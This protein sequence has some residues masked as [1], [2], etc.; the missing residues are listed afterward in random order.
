MFVDSDFP[1]YL[2]SILWLWD[3]RW[4]SWLKSGFHMFSYV[5]M[6]F[7]VEN[8]R[9]R[10]MRNQLGDA[11]PSLPSIFCG[12]FCCVSYCWPFQN[13]DTGSDKFTPAGRRVINEL[14]SLAEMLWDLCGTTF[15][16]RRC[17]LRRGVPTWVPRTLK[18]HIEDWYYLTWPIP[19]DSIG[20]TPR[21]L[22]LVNDLEVPWHHLGQFDQGIRSCH[23]S[24]FNALLRRNIFINSAGQV[25]QYIQTETCFWNLEP[26]PQP[27][28]PVFDCPVWPYLCRIQRPRERRNQCKSS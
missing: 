7:H 14:R 9:L 13:Q 6:C 22:A 4:L 2:G 1:M 25:G 26:C 10:N 15:D 16:V 20:K 19:F 8:P 23:F 28:R 21:N 27:P 24:I 17:T 3:G 18:Q 5:F 12:G 11:L